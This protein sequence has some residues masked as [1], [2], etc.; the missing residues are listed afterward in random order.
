[1][2]IPSIR[3]AQRRGTA[4][5]AIAVATA[6]LLS[7]CGSPTVENTGDQDAD[8]TVPTG[9]ADPDGPM[10]VADAAA[11][12]SGTP[13]TVQ[14]FLIEDGGVLFVSESIAESFP[15][16]PG[17]VRMEVEGIDLGQVDGV[18]EEGPIRWLDNPVSISGTVDGGRIIGAALAD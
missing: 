17:G 4:T 12:D 16:Q 9:D 5:A 15:P 2:P 8:N 6:L 18:N 11:A 14:G 7:A 10:T 13:V 3:P 1:M